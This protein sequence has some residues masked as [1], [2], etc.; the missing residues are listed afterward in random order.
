M[1]GGKKPM[2]PKAAK[3]SPDMKR[4]A[5]PTTGVS[6]PA[7]PAKASKPMMPKPMGEQKRNFLPKGE[8]PMAPKPA[9]PKASKPMMPKR[10][11]M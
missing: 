5:L 1:M 9:M 11:K 7:S 2:M 4:Y 3:P 6:K 10:T 8:M